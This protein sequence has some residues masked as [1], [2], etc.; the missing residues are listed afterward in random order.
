MNIATLRVLSNFDVIL[1]RK[2]AKI[3][4]AKP[5][6]CE[7]AG[8]KFRAFAK[9]VEVLADDLKPKTQDLKPI[10]KSFNQLLDRANEGLVDR[11]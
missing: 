2:T 1:G 7:K 8:L 6:I 5:P 4:T 9:S 10:N 3:I 11:F